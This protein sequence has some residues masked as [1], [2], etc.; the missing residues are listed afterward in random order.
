MRLVAA[1]PPSP[2][3]EAAQPPV[4]FPWAGASIGVLLAMVGLV[5]LVRVVPRLRRARTTSG[6]IVEVGRERGFEGRS[7]WRLHVEF[8][9]AAGAVRRG[10]WI[11]QS[12]LDLTSYRPGMLVPVRYDPQDGRVIDLPGG[13]RPHAVLVPSLL[14][15]FGLMFAVA[16]WFITS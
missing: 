4:W 11:G 14:L 5:W 1:P 16:F 2:A 9:D 6:V 15:G 3:F 10:L 7:M 8:A 12:S 13:L